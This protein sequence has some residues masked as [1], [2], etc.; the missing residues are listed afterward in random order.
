MQVAVGTELVSGSNHSTENLT[1]LV[2][3]KIAGIL[4]KL[5]H[6]F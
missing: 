5:E 6:I 4:L 1:E 2:E 3:Q